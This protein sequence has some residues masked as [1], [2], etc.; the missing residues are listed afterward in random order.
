MDIF[1][2]KSLEIH[3]TYLL[4]RFNFVLRLKFCSN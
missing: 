3:E 1:E 2:A 4:S